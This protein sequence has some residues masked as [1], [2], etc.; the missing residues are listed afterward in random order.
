MLANTKTLCE[1]LGA[2]PFCYNVLALDTKH[3]K[4]CNCAE[5]EFLNNRVQLCADLLFNHHETLHFHVGGL[6]RSPGLDQAGVHSLQGATELVL[7]QRHRQQLV[8]VRTF[9]SK[10]K[11]QM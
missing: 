9:C 7:P 3:L 10:P 1:S 11:T 8:N 2:G 6:Q 5:R 4:A